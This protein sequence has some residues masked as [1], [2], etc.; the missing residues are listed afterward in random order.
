M[1]NSSPAAIANPAHLELKT[2]IEAILRPLSAAIRV[3]Q[4]LV[5][6]IQNKHRKREIERRRFC[7][8]SVI[9][10]AA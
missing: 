2:R 5:K 7:M 10:D 6:E 3:F 9:I 4:Q 1:Y 8:Y